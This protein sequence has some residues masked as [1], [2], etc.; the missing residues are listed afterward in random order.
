MRRYSRVSALIDR[1]PPMVLG[2]PI[3]LH[4]GRVVT[5]LRR[6]R[7]A[8]ASRVVGSR[9]FGGLRSPEGSEV[10]RGR[11]HSRRRVDSR[12]ISRTR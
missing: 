4:F 6:R 8:A 7:S 3:P 2:G 11:V 12:A 1:W 5:G 9:L 10:G